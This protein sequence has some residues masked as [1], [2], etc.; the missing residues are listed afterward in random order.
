MNRLVICVKSCLHDL[1]RGCHDIIRSSWG[2]L[3]ID[4]R[5]FVGQKSLHFMEDEIF[6]NCDDSY[7]GLSQKTHEICK[8]AITQPINY[9]FLCD[10]D[11]FVMPEKLLKSGFEN[12]D[13]IGKVDRPFGKTFSYTDT[14]RHGISEF[15][16]YCHPWAS[17]GFGYFLS[18]KAFTKI[19]QTSSAFSC[20]ED[21]WVGQVLGLLI[22]FGEMTGLDI[23]AGQYSYH[24][25]YHGESYDTELLGK[26][27][28]RINEEFNGR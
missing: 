18:R 5:F 4:V 11:T 22:A 26:W 3:G 16:E 13:Y 20:W 8:W 10:T 28:R 21:L 14:D 17:G 12:Y 2:K 6:L 24:Y 25:P 15:H 1:Q 9:L 19:A 7:D 27:M 23:P